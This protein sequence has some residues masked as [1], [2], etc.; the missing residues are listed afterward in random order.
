V[1]TRGQEAPWLDSVKAGLT[2]VFVR[3][4]HPVLRDPLDLVRLSFLVGAVVYATLG[5][6]NATVRL[7]APGFFVFLVRAI[8]VPRPVDWT[9][10]LAMLFQG[11]GNAAHL[12]SE[13]W[14]YDNLVH[15]TLPMSL[16]PILYTSGSHDWMSCPS[17]PSAPVT[18]RS[19]SGW[20]SSPSVWG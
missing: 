1:T 20:R 12:F 3:D 17:R 8:D 14:W 2:L 19:W 5:D 9:F 18:R 6:W 4:W 10:C 13:F 15:I 7:L 16:A 11:W